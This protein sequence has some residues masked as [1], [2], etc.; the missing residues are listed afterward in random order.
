VH[1]S[2]LVKGLAGVFAA[3]TSVLIVLGLAYNPAILMPAL[4]FA[5]VTYLFYQHGSGALAQRLY[6]RVERQAANNAS[7]VQGRGGFGAGPREEWTPPRGGATAAGQQ[8]RHR[9][10]RN[11]DAHEEAR[12]ARQ[13]RRQRYERTGGNGRR[14]PTAPTGPTRAEAYRILGLGDSADA[15][16]VKQAYRRKVKEVH[17]DT[18]GGDEEA[19]KRVTEAYE[20]LTDD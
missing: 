3:M 15:D 12:R 11:Q 13:R 4:I 14:P 5:I 10:H 20:T 9:R 16:S 19:F 1:R 2:R 8:Q 18:D 6:G 7:R 17:P